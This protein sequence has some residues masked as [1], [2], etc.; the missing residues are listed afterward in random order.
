M[1]MVDSILYFT[2][3]VEFLCRGHVDRGTNGDKIDVVGDLS[4]QKVL[5]V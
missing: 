2:S 3:V 5:Y 4:K 1:V